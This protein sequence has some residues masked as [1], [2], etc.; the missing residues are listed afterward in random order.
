MPALK[1]SAKVETRFI[2]L[3]ANRRPIGSFE[4]RE[5]WMG[6]SRMDCE[7][8]TLSGETIVVYTPDPARPQEPLEIV[9]CTAKVRD[10]IEAF[11]PAG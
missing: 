10:A 4:L 8:G 1:V 2:L 9:K 11:S 3:D 6:L 7:S 5:S